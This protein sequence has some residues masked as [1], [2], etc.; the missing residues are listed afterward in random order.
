MGA[1]LASVKERALLKNHKDRVLL[2]LTNKIA[3]RVLNTQGGASAQEDHSAK[4][5]GALPTRQQQQGWR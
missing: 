3:V 2:L 4:V 5:V 1:H